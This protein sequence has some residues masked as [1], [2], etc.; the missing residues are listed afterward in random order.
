MTELL[1]MPCCQHHF[2]VGKSHDITPVSDVFVVLEPLLSCHDC[3]QISY[4]V[5]T[6]IAQTTNA[7][8]QINE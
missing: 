6:A 5:I 2:D 3:S 4:I 7:K 8:K 1:F